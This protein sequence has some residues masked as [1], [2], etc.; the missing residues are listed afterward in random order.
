MEEGWLS[1]HPAP[2]VGTQA[3]GRSWELLQLPGFGAGLPWVTV[4]TAPNSFQ[5][6]EP[7]SA[8]MVQATVSSFSLW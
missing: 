3:T 8:E 6:Q 2:K 4:Q 7:G 5:S 1:Q